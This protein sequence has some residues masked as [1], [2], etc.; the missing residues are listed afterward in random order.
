MP[1]STKSPDT[2][3]SILYAL[4]ANVAIAA[5]KL[6]GALFTGSS[7]LLAEGLHSLADSGN[8]ALLLY[9][10]RQARL[11]P[12]AH[13][14][15]GHGR[16][17][18]FW[19]F[20]VALLLFSIGGVFS[21]YEGTRK[22]SLAEPIE[23]PWIAVAIV[24]FALAAEGTS[25]HYSLRQIGKV[26]RERSLWRWFRETRRSELIVVLSEDLAA[27]AGLCFA[28]A[29]LLLTVTTGDPLWDA[30]GSIAIGTLLIVVASGLAAEVKS[31]LIGESASPRT[32]RAIRD[33]LNSRPGIEEVE[34]L[35]TLQQGDEVLIAVR[36]RLGGATAREVFATMAEVKAA[37]RAEFPEV[38]WIFFE[39]MAKNGGAAPGARSA[40]RARSRT[41]RSRDSA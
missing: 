27:I 9:G 3:R 35:V 34:Q 17:K 23:A 25:L 7:A 14:P 5:A 13:H 22:L 16:A 4:A 20:V 6:T 2:T 21:I 10:R 41:R 8:E 30:I 26:R 40:L 33:F 38:A 12:S 18:Y 39:P 31:L 28:L 36:A 37:L 1:R 11:P 19:S 32:R 24:V 29:A 15:L